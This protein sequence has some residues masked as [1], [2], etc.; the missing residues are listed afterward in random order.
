MS[1]PKYDTEWYRKR[2]VILYASPSITIE[3]DAVAEVVDGAT[4]EAWVQAWVRV[5]IEP[6]CVGKVSLWLE[7]KHPHTTPWLKIKHHAQD[8]DALLLVEDIKAGLGGIGWKASS[9]LAPITQYTDEEGYVG[10]SLSPPPGK[11]L[12]NAWKELERNAFLRA[13]ERKLEELGFAFPPWF[14]LSHQD[15]A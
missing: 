6:Q 15:L 12:F 9:F 10:F 4:N 14:H 7:S 8:E 3:E 1:S 2:A 13:L 5:P 11:G